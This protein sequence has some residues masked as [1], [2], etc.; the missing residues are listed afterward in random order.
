MPGR[1]GDRRGDYGAHALTEGEPLADTRSAS[2]AGRSQ[3]SGEEGCFVECGSRADLS[4]PLAC[5]RTCA[6]SDA[7][8][9]ASPS[10][11]RVARRSS[12]RR[13]HPRRRRDAATRSRSP[14]LMRSA[15]CS[16]IVARIASFTCRGSRIMCPA[17]A[18]A[19][20]N[21]LDRVSERSS[22]PN[23]QTSC[24]ES[25]SGKTLPSCR[26]AGAVGSCVDHPR[27]TVC[28]RCLRGTSLEAIRERHAGIEEWSSELLD[29]NGPPDGAHSRQS[30]GINPVRKSLGRRPA[31]AVFLTPAGAS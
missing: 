22:H 21:G 29:G 15:C 31:V 7:G 18:D 8:S 6:S 25:I 13:N 12:Q 11:M 9:Q 1:C 19:T 24:G 23:V 26:L 14:S 5:L 30:T 16:R 10:A 17:Y 20:R 27:R 2:R 3:A 4:M 28:D